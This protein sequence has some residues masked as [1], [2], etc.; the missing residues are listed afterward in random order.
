MKTKLACGGTVKGKMI[1][2]QGDHKPIEYRHVMI[3]PIEKP[4][5]KK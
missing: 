4:A 1:E 2:L 5:E 3:K